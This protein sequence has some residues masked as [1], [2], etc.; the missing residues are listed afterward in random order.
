M[1]YKHFYL[2]IIFRIALL[3]L[4]TALCTYLCFVSKKYGLSIFVFL[5]VIA[6]GVSTI[7]YFNNINQWIAFFLLGIENEDTTLK[8]PRKTGSKAIDDVFKGMDRL[9]EIFKQTKIEIS[10]QE[11]YFRSVIDQ[12]A[13]G[14]MAIDSLGRVININPAATK[15]TQLIQFHHINTL[16]K[17]DPS[18]PEFLAK[19]TKLSEPVSAIYDNHRGQKLL[20]KVTKIQTSTELIKL[21]AVSDIT[22][23]LDNREVDAWVKLA[24][25]LAHEIMNNITPITTLSQVILNYFFQENKAL[26]IEKIEQK[27]ID[28]SIKGLKVIEERSSGLL[29]FVDNYRKFTKIPEP[30]LKKVDLVTVIEKNLLASSAYKGFDQVKIEKKLPIQLEVETDENLLSQVLINLI[31]NAIENFTENES[32]NNPTIE[33]KIQADGELN[34]IDICNNGSKIP[35]ELREQIFIPFFTT[36]ENG[37][38]IGLSLSKQ[39][40]LKLGGDIVL[41][42]NS[43]GFTCFSVYV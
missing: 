19:E 42:T 9:N 6:T 12:S 24:R 35:A 3:V 13:T 31:K 2:A 4:L 26:P 30:V 27:T 14:L 20:F 15:L 17:I 22:K 40:M 8:I 16:S 32:I 34:R 29:N 37:S 28:N 11:Q 33:I 21:V 41:K 25:T 39:I 1:N 10:T 36:K 23:E 38:G 43:R 5:I 7:R 18:L